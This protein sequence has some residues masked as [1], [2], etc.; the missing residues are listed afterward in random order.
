[1]TRHF[2]PGDLIFI[3]M[4][5]YPS[6]PAKVDEVPNGTVKPPTNKLP[7]SLLG[8]HETA[9]LGPK[10]IVPYSENTESMENQINEKALMKAYG[11]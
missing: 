3:K 2:E 4:T 7:I 11:K 9:F 8:T 1:M 10:D 6:C 5:G